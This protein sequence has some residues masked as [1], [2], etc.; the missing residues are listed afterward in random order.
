[1][2]IIGEKLKSFWLIE[3][4]LVDSGLVIYLQSVKPEQQ[5]K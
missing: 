3:L 4:T 5:L 1:M 2:R